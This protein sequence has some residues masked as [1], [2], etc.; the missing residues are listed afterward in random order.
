MDYKEEGKLAPLLDAIL[1]R[2]DASYGVFPLTN[3]PDKEDD[4]LKKRDKKRVRKPKVKAVKIK[5]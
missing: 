3:K 4:D 5:F 1:A 2:A